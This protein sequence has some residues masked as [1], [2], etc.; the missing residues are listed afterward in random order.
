MFVSGRPAL[1][2]VHTLALGSLASKLMLVHAPVLG[3][4]AR[5][6][7]LTRPSH[8]PMIFEQALVR[9]LISPDILRM[10]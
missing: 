9:A 4:L 10:F 3:F 8:V 1:A 6:P 7:K 5:N 2:I